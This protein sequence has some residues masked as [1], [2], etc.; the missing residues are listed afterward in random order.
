LILKIQ[1]TPAVCPKQ[2]NNGNFYNMTSGNI[3]LEVQQKRMRETGENTKLAG[4]GESYQKK[5]IQK[6]AAEKEV[7]QQNDERYIA[8]CH[9]V[10]NHYPGKQDPTLLV[11]LVSVPLSVTG[12]EKPTA[13]LYWVQTDSK[14]CENIGGNEHNS[15]GNC[16]ILSN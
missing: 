7:I 1:E 2:F 11:T 3:R 13:L 14:R 15:V 6:K 16:H 12:I 9:F 8:I 10:K 5:K 4:K